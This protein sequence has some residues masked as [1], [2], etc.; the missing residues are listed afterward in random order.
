MGRTSVD[1]SYRDIM[2]RQVGKRAIGKNPTDP[3][4]IAFLAAEILTLRAATAGLTPAKWNIWAANAPPPVEFLS[5]QLGW[6]VRTRLNRRQR[7]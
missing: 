1:K 7:K 5:D 4:D 6:W 3:E 2:S